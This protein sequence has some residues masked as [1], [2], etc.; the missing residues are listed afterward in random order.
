MEHL[1]ERCATI[2]KPPLD[3]SSPDTQSSSSNTENNQQSSLTKTT[4]EL[5]NE[6]LMALSSNQFATELPRLNV[7]LELLIELLYDLLYSLPHPVVPRRLADLC[8]RA[9]E[10]GYENAKF[11]LDFFPRSHSDLFELISKFLAFYIK[12]FL[13]ESRLLESG[14]TRLLAEAVFQLPDSQDTNKQGK[15]V[16]LNAQNAVKFLN[17][18]VRNYG[19]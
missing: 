12:C 4:E 2:K 16:D 15:L 19:F 9:S 10:L 8:S 3:D 6:A 18:F 1:I 14:L 7:D 11:L 13:G 17:L 5:K